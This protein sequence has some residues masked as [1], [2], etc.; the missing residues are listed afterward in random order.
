VAVVE[1]FEDLEHVEANVEVVEALVQ[2]AEISVA[3]VNELG[4][5][6]RRLGKRVSDNINEFDNVDTVLEGLENLDL[7]TDLVFLHGLQDF[8]DNALIVQSVDSFV[9]FRVLASTDL[10][11][12]LIVVLGPAQQQSKL[13]NEA[14]NQ[15]TD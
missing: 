1:S 11:D 6:G 14:R 8:D 7:A 12:D 5:D 9:H 15:K 10:L 13:N 2:F 3:R 4:D